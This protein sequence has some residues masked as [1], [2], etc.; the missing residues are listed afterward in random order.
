[1]GRADF[2]LPSFFC[3]VLSEENRKG[4]RQRAAVP[5]AFPFR[6][7]ASHVLL[8]LLDQAENTS[9][10]PGA[11][12]FLVE[13]QAN[14]SLKFFKKNFHLSPDDGVGTFSVSKISSHKLISDD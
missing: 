12:L 8:A 13:K 7:A 5:R 10:A 2:Y 6:F 9:A 14:K 11:Q 1:M 3:F 4:P